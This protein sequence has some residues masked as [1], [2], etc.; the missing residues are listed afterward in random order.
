MVG[1]LDLAARGLHGAGEDLFAYGRQRR[2]DLCQVAHHAAQ[3]ERRR[4]HGVVDTRVADET[5]H[6]EGLGDTHGTRRRDALGRGGSLQRGGRKRRGRLLL[7]RALGHRGDGCRRNAV[8]MAVRRLS[9]ILVG[10]ARRLVSDL[11]AIVLGSTLR[12]A[13]A[14]NLPIVLGHKRH[15]LALALDHQGKRRRLHAAGGAHVAK[16]AKL[17]ERQVARE[18]R[19]P[20]EVDVLTT[21]AG[22]G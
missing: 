15:A 11:K 20:D 13:H 8:N 16:A 5:G 1:G 9:S 17:G 14:T 21:L 4:V 12:G 18:H 7:A 22:I 3:V 6:V 10:K 2:I 19:A